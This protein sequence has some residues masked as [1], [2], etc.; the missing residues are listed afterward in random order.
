MWRVLHAT[1]TAPLSQQQRRSYAKEVLSCRE[2]G[3]KIIYKGYPC[4]CCR[5]CVAA[6]AAAAAAPVSLLLRGLQR[7][8]RQQLQ[9]E[10]QQHQP[11]ELATGQLGLL[12]GMRWLHTQKQQRR[13]DEH[14]GISS[15]L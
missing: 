3:Q 11:Q 10:Q 13:I 2:F 9:H 12:G 4:C 1:Q 8:S 6:A 14:R 15:I 7:S 5:G